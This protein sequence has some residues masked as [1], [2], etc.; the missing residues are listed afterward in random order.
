MVFL[1]NGKEAPILGKITMDM[2]IVDVSE[3]ENINIGDEVVIIG[4]S[5][6]KK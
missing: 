1:V 3:I 6:D 5:G 4:E 2:T